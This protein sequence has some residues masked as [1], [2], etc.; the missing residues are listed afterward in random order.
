MAI[1]A[2][3]AARQ[4]TYDDYM[5]GPTFEGR[6]DIIDGVKLDMPTP[7]WWHQRIVFRVILA[8]AEYESRAGTVLSL[9]APYDILLSRSP[10]RTRQPDVLLISKKQLDLGGGAP[11]IGPIEVAPELVVEIIS[12]SETQRR[13]A[14]KIADYAR[15]GVREVWRI[16]VEAATLE[17]IDLAS[18]VPVSTGVYQRL[19]AI[20]SLTFTDLT[21]Q[22]SSI[23]QDLPQN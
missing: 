1:A 16:E 6:Y 22:L 4:M 12:N 5:N 3:P 10:L 15:I 11:K 7:S 23:F 13:F 18:G 19:E 14:G 9:T 8:F 17:V 2:P 21:V 20:S